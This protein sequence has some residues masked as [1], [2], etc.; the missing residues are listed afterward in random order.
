MCAGLSRAF[1]MSPASTPPDTAAPKRLNDLPGEIIAHIATTLVVAPA[2]LFAMSASNRSLLA[3]LVEEGPRLWEEVARL[4]LG[5]AAIDLVRQATRA[6]DGPTPIGLSAYR[7]SLLL[8]QRVS[9]G[10]EVVCGSVAKNATDMEVVACPCLGN[11]TNFG[12]GAQGVIREAAGPAFEAGLKDV[13]YLAPL[14]ALL[15]PGGRLAPYVAMVVTTAPEELHYMLWGRDAESA[16]S[17]ISKRMH[18]NLFAAM[19]AAGL[20]SVAMP[21]LGTG[22][23]GYRAGRVC[24]GLAMAY[25]E[26]FRMHPH[27]PMR[28]RVACYEVSHLLHARAAKKRALDGLFEVMDS[29][30]AYL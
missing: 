6:I 22:G 24:D 28:V 23:Q 26:D 3:L 7:S 5:P 16:V 10:F 12:M 8:R 1:A 18:A 21:T 17:T 2:S 25:A 15:V 27:L 11:L 29:S 19:R 14:T 30:P 4:Q 13:A 20:R 9:D